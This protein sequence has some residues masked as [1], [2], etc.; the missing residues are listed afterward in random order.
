MKSILLKIY[1][2]FDSLFKTKYNPSNDQMVKLSGKDI[3]IGKYTYG[4]ESTQI[5]SWGEDIDIKIG[6][7]S[8]IG[9]GLK[10]FC[11]GNH[12]TSFVSS[13]PFGSVYPNFLKVVF[14]KSIVF[15]N[16]DIKIGNDVWIGRDVTVMSGISIGDGSVIAANSHVVKNVEPYS[17]YGGN[18]AK[19]IR[20]KFSEEIIE[21]LLKLQWWNYEDDII[22]KIYP[23]LLDNPNKDTY[24][25]IIKILEIHNPK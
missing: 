16:G 8:S 18:P 25:K 15:S 10:L 1:F 14:D 22:E 7:F 13:Y 4:F 20:Y 11:G 24:Y 6:R 21:M 9:A 19:F 23:I 12:S 3:F 2:F 17:I 5:Y